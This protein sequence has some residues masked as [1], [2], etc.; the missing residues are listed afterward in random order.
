MCSRNIGSKHE[1]D[2]TA[3]GGAAASKP[4]EV[5]D[6]KVF[7]SYELPNLPSVAANRKTS[8]DMGHGNQRNKF[9]LLEV[10]WERLSSCQGGSLDMLLSE[11]MHYV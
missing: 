7:I 1:P 10:N 5:G 11:N 9:I 3:L 4:F 6:T 8:D 2:A